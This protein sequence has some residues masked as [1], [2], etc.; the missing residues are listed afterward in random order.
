MDFK[1]GSNRNIPGLKTTRHQPQMSLLNLVRVLFGASAVH[2][3]RT[4]CPWPRLGG[5]GGFPW[6]PRPWRDRTAAPDHLGWPTDSSCSRFPNDCGSTS[7]T[8]ARCWW[9]HLIVSPAFFLAPIHVRGP[10]WR[11]DPKPNS[12]RSRAGSTMSIRL[13]TPAPSNTMPR[14]SWKSPAAGS[15]GMTARPSPWHPPE[16]SRIVCRTNPPAHRRRR[17]VS[18]YARLPKQ[19]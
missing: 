7:A 18:N 5:R 8:I 16:P 3:P 13:T 19:H 10:S 1:T 2:P 12:Y 6:T 17:V 14:R 9:S 4:R 11:D 15:P